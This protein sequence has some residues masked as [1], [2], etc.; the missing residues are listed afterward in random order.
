MIGRNV[1]LIYLVPLVFLT[2][3]E[4]TKK[5]DEKDEKIIRECIHLSYLSH[6]SYTSVALDESDIQILKTYVRASW[7]ATCG[8]CLTC[9]PGSRSLRRSAEKDGSGHQGCAKA[10]KRET[11]YI[12]RHPRVD[13]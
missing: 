7:H 8:F 1:R 11:R 10:N 13:D 2:A 3:F 4:D 12:V 6:L 9:L 5:I